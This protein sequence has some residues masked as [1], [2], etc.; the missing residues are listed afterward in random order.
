MSLG[1]L[2]QL[3]MDHI[4]KHY[5]D[6][7][8]TVRQ[9]A[10]TLTKE[11]GTPYAYNT[12]LTVMTHLFKKELLLRRK[13][14]KTCVYRIAMTKN[15]FV[16]TVSK[17]VFTNLKKQYGPLAIGHFANLLEKIDTKTLKSARDYVKHHQFAFFIGAATA[18]S[19]FIQT[20]VFANVQSFFFVDSTESCEQE[21]R[22][23][24]QDI[25]SRDT[26]KQ[27]RAGVNSGQCS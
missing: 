15:E 16:A 4:W 8:F 27:S 26:P 1:T 6:E 21:F 5:T 18:L 24:S 22:V 19:L 13:I 17:Q 2:E 10:D 3:V 23:Q 9:V 25:Q 14:G 12:I 11:C 7:P 20:P